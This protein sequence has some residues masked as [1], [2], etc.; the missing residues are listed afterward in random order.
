MCHVCVFLFQKA[1]VYV[2]PTTSL[3][4]RTFLMKQADLSALGFRRTV[5]RPDGSR[6]VL[7]GPQ[8]RWSFN[9]DVCQGSFRNA[10][11][12]AAHRLFMKHPA[13]P[14]AAVP[15]EHPPL[16]PLASAPAPSGEHP[17][18]APHAADPG[19]CEDD[20]L[21]GEAPAAKAGRKGA[22]TRQHPC[23]HFRPNHGFLI[24]CC[25]L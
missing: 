6:E 2:F 13:P 3:S 25:F 19:P 11:A 14:P 17:P 24:G 18:L 20:P 21:P 4:S 10:G 8:Q 15:E 12:L 16:P 1:V 22:A 5:E 7:P 23:G 9:C